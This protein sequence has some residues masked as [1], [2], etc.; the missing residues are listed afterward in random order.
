MRSVLFGLLLAACSSPAAETVSV[1]P[2]SLTAPPAPPTA[3]PVA[4]PNPAPSA[5]PI[6]PT[7]PFDRELHPLSPDA[8]DCIEMIS[9]CDAEG[10]CTSTPV[11]VACGTTARVG[12][13][14]LGCSCP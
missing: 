2:P 14:I 11:Y 4:P 7:A 8:P 12:R 13:E 5:G 3:P 9:T 6:R 10:L 1:A